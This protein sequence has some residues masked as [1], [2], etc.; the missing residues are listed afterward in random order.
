MPSTNF[1][2]QWRA[3]IIVARKP[4]IKS[5]IYCFAWHKLQHFA[6]R[7]HKT[8]NLSKLPSSHL[9]I[10][11]LKIILPSLAW[12]KFICSSDTL[13]YRKIYPFRQVLLSV[14]KKTLSKKKLKETGA[15]RSTQ[16]IRKR[17]HK[18]SQCCYIEKFRKVVRTLYRDM[19]M[20][21]SVSERS[22]S[23]GGRRGV[24]WC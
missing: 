22:N 13:R 23:Y 12:V 21:V 14:G 18:H 19:A 8:S 20:T 24:D 11:H 17:K 10:P 16:Y 2:R 7:F 9:W 4:N 15:L 5:S 1:I 6:L 3:D